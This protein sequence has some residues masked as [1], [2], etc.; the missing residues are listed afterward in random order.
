[1]DEERKAKFVADQIVVGASIV[2]LRGQS[3]TEKISKLIHDGV[4][5]F[6]QR[7]KLRKL[8]R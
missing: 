8:R 1:M 7:Q 3:P 6:N 5:F 2:N 4:S